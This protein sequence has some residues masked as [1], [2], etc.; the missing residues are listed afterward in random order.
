MAYIRGLTVSKIDHFQTAAKHNKPR[1]DISRYTVC[2]L[3]Y[4]PWRNCLYLIKMFAV[5]KNCW[6]QLALLLDQISVPYQ[7]EFTTLSRIVLIIF[8]EKILSLKS[9]YYICG[10]HL[11]KLIIMIHVFIYD[12]RFDYFLWKNTFFEIPLLHLSVD[13]TLWSWSWWY[14]CIW[15]KP[16]FQQGLSI[17]NY[18]ISK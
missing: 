16:S 10:Q 8:F 7:N 2:W 3:D 18:D 1:T 5:P 14:T 15:I 9:P 12:T 4:C 13:N 17:V 6:S 11:V